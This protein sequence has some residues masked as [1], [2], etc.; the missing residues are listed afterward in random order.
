MMVKP[1]KTREHERVGHPPDTL[2]RWII[3]G[4][5]PLLGIVTGGAVILD[6]RFGLTPRELAIPVSAFT[7]IQIA[8]YLSMYWVRRRRR[9]RLGIAISG[10]YA[11]SAGILVIHY[12]SRWGFLTRVGDSDVSWFALTIAF[13]TLVGVLIM[14]KHG[15]DVV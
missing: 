9:L 14:P 8:C 2:S 12:G 7:A 11:L 10:A 3:V 5:L 15:P 6:L 13:V 4:M 1:R